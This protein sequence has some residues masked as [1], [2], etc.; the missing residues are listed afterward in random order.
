MSCI[1]HNI[2]LLLM[3]LSRFDATKSGRSEYQ[4]LA[5]MMLTGSLDSNGCDLYPEWNAGNLSV[6]LPI[7]KR[8]FAYPF[9]T[10]AL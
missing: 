5:N 7:F 2:L 3:L 10:E 8:Q 1:E 9:M 6:E 4:A